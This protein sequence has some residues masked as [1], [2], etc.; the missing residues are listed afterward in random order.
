MTENQERDL[1]NPYVWEHDAEVIG[2]N[3][4]TGFKDYR[5]RDCGA[6]WR[7]MLD[8]ENSTCP[9]ASKEE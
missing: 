6:V 8:E 7:E 1:S 5:C 2:E 4:M 9:A 3:D